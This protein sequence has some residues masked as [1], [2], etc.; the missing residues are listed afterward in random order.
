MGESAGS[1]NPG[2]PLLPPREPGPPSSWSGA[3]RCAKTAGIPWHW[4]RRDGPILGDA[5]NRLARREMGRPLPPDG[6]ETQ[7]HT[8]DSGSLGAISIS[9]G[10]NLQCSHET[11][12]SSRWQLVQKPRSGQLWLPSPRTVPCRRLAPLSA[13]LPNIRRQAKV[14]LRRGS[15]TSFHSRLYG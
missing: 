2:R 14:L 3:R 13:F 12:P 5:A 7:R 10:A 8:A 4:R 15:V 11:M 9:M 1:G 6:P